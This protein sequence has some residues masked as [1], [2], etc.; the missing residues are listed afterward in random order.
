MTKLLLADV[1]SLDN[2]ALY[3]H[4][5]LAA[6]SHRRSLADSFR[7]RKDRNL[8]IGA[9]ALLDSGLRSLGIRECDMVY[10]SMENG[11]PFFKNLT[12]IHFNISHSCS[13]VAVAFSDG[14]IGCD[15]EH[16][17]DIEMDVAESFFSKSEYQSI[18]SRNGHDE[19]IKS[20]FRYWTLKESYMK[21]TGMGMF[22]K[23]DSFTISSGSDGSFSVSGGPDSDFVFITPVSFVGYDCALCYRP[24]GG[25]PEVEFVNL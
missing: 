17:A 8:S 19:R 7:F 6:S 18:I 21:A 13:K 22:L 11:K 1:T 10:G 14:D 16:I 4:Y 25:H 3:E 2:D 20:F 12:D 15:I 5:Y 24:K 9:A 23:S